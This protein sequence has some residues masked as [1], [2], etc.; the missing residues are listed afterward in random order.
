MVAAAQRGCD[1]SFTELISRHRC[2]MY[3][4]CFKITRC[5]EDAEEALAE[6]EL[7]LFKYISKFKRESKYTSWCYRVTANCALQRLKQ[8]KRSK[9]RLELVRDL[10]APDPIEIPEMRLAQQAALR[11]AVAKLTD[12]QKFL[13]V[14]R[15]RDN[16]PFEILGTL[17]NLPVNNVKTR[18]Y[19]MNQR[20]RRLLKPWKNT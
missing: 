14:A 13:F 6:A 20:L 11:K 3:S 4:L 9:A 15:H 5:E 12:E 18:C 19:R 16:I 8:R 1:A 10:P 7:L 2:K 17:M